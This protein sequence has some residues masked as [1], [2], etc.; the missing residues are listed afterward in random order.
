[1]SNTQPLGRRSNASLPV[2]TASDNLDWS[3]D[4]YYADRKSVLKVL[5]TSTQA[6]TLSMKFGTK[7]DAIGSLPHTITESVSANTSLL[8]VV[9]LIPGVDAGRIFFTNGSGGVTSYTFDAGLEEA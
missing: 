4:S 7:A 3:A 2:S 5:I 1:M 8:L 9:P 6:G